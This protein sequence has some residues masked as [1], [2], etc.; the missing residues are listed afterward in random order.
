MNFNNIETVLNY[1]FNNPAILK[2]ALTHSSFVN[3]KSKMLNNERLEFLGDAVLELVV[4]SY[5]YKN[6]AYSSEGELTKLRAKIVCTESLAMVSNV[7]NLGSYILLGKGEEN[8]GGRNRKSILANSFEAIIGAIY[9]DSSIEQAEKFILS[10]M[11]QNMKD[12]IK[13]RLI[14]DY[15]TKIQEL[16]QQNSSNIIEYTVESEQGPEHDKLFNINLHL[17]G[18]IIGT[19]CGSSKKEAEQRAAYNGLIFLGEING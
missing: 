17:N 11:D 12:A 16:I 6:H 1:K 19:G 13:G 10:K 3:E 14:F 8:T 4:S 5:L 9:I 15:K 18:E 2:N 7:L